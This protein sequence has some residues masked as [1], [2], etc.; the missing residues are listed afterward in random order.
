MTLSFE[1]QNL[2]KHKVSCSEVKEVLGSDLSFGEDLA[3]SDFGNDRTMIIG[4]TFEGRILEVGIEYF[5]NEDRE[6]VFHAMDAGKRYKKE[7][8][9]RCGI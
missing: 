3:P 2:R 7:F 1:D 5:E 8:L 6:H 9:T 4:W